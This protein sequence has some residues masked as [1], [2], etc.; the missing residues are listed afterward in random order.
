M[1]WDNRGRRQ[2]RSR[3]LDAKRETQGRG[4]APARDPEPQAGPEAGTQL[5]VAGKRRG[6]DTEVWHLA[7]L[8]R[9]RAQ[10]SG[11]ELAKGLPV[12][13]TEISDLVTRY[14]I[15]GKSFRQMATG[16]KKRTAHSRLA[17]HCWLHWPPLEP[18][19]QHDREL[20]W[21]QVVE[22]IIAEF[23]SRQWDAHALDHFR[24]HFQ[25]Y[26]QLALNHWR[27]LRI[28]Q[29]I[30]SQPPRPRAVMR[31]QEPGGTMADASKEG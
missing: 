23:W 29:D 21:V 7:E 10:A 8:F 3:P 17:E 27:S 9:Q 28:A 6:R 2:K 5:P 4:G 19:R 13:C 22:V 20:T 12:I 24:Q 14:G 26:G 16:C 25:E 11:I 15:R 18:A 1:G 31:R 30:A